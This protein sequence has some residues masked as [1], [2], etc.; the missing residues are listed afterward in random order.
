MPRRSLVAPI[1]H[2]GAPLGLIHLGDAAEDYDDQDA[3]LMMRISII[4]A[5]VLHGRLD[6]DKLTPRKAR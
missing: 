3:D 5:P 1:M 2:A 6:R 4:V